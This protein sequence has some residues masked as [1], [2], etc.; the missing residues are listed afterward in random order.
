MAITIKN[1]NGIY[2]VKESPKTFTHSFPVTTARVKCF[3]GNA[4]PDKMFI[5][6][7]VK[8]DDEIAQ[9][10]IITYL[11]IYRER[12]LNGVFPVEVLSYEVK[13]EKYEI[14]AEMVR[15]HGKLAKK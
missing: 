2:K 15:K 12:L 14:S 8:I 1:E 3:T 6:K 9:L 13:E 11:N 4:E 5:E 7:T 10:E